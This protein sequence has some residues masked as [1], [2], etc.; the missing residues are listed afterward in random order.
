[1][2]LSFPGIGKCAV[3][4]LLTV[5]QKICQYKWYNT[6]YTTNKL[7]AEVTTIDDV[8]LPE[9]ARAITAI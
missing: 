3:L 1:M 6:I 9:Q 5:E 4:S 8:L 7:D 2:K